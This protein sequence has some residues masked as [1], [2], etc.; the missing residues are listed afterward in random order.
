MKKML[1][2]GLLLLHALIAGAQPDWYKKVAAQNDDP[3]NFDIVFHP[4]YKKG[5]T[6]DGNYASGYYYAKFN[7]ADF[8]KIYS[9]PAHQQLLETIAV[10]DAN[11]NTFANYFQKIGSNDVP[12]FIQALGE[13]NEYVGYGTKLLD[14]IQ[15]LDASRKSNAN[16][17]ATLIAPRGQFERWEI[18]SSNEPDKYYITL[19]NIY[20]ITVGSEERKYVISRH[21]QAVDIE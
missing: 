9:R 3:Y 21:V 13:L 11:K 8:N 19:L 7:K 1:V 6:L 14:V 15:A 5:L 16:T 4:F 2:S 18:F 17:L 12:F 10:T 20:K